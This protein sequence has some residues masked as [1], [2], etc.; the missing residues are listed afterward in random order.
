MTALP[1]AEDIRQW[2][3]SYQSALLN[4]D[5]H[6]RRRFNDIM[7][8]RK[9]ALSLERAHRS[10]EER[11]VIAKGYADAIVRHAAALRAEAYA[12]LKLTPPAWA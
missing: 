2:T 3:T 5:Y 6:T 4:A 11:G 12:L 7:A 9:Q 10:A 8:Q 1:T